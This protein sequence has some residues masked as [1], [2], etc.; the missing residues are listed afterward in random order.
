MLEVL[1]F[2]V[3]EPLISDDD[4]LD[5]STTLQQVEINYA[6]YIMCLSKNE[7]NQAESFIAYKRN[8]TQFEEMNQGIPERIV[9]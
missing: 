4:E 1:Y 3:R 8:V 2:Y 9:G 7:T 6:C 5:L